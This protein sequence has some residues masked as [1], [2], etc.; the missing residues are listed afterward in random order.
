MDWKDLSG[1]DEKYAK[2]RIREHKTFGGK[3][4]E[5]LY[6]AKDEN[7]NPVMARE[8]ADDGHG[9]WFGIDINGD[10]RMFSLQKPASEGG[11]IEYATES[12]DHAL[13][14]MENT[15][16]RKQEIC[17][18]LLGILNSNESDSMQERISALEE[19]WN[20]LKDWNTPKEENFAKRYAQLMDEFAHHQNVIKQNVLDKQAIVEKAKE[21]AESTSWKTAQQ[22]FENLL[23][24]LKNIGSAGS[25]DDEI[26]QQF[27]EARSAFN[28]KRS[29]YFSQL[30]EIRAASKV[31]KEELIGQAK[32]VLENKN[33]KAATDK[34]NAL[35]E[36]WKKAGSSGRDFDDIL[37]EQF[38][39]IRKEF[40]D[41]RKAFYNEM[42]EAQKKSSEIKNSL[43]EEVR[44]IVENADF[45][46]DIT[47]RMKE[48][49]K[50]W[51]AAGFS[52]KEIN[53]A[54][55]ETFKEVKNQFWDA[56]HANSQDR[57]RE[58][59][60]RKEDTLKKIRTE[61]DDLQV[62]EY[63]TEDYDRIHS[64]QKRIEEKKVTAE[65]IE[66]D[67]KELNE[68]LDKQ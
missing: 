38:N 18:E 6:G 62:K 46:K 68:K 19:E 26:Y 50:E 20:G 49:D 54:L 24:E 5:V 25:L 66:N 67:I 22:G 43:I 41:K 27:K 53:D 29:E 15:I 37:W 10:H 39:G 47:E 63:E 44:K 60:S 16:I 13:E 57:F 9:R 4:V 55:W 1:F 34:M 21:L 51:K 23:K 59:I 48:I 58:I 32:E 42:R 61:I 31:K 30:D 8:G 7:G 56:K 65:S 35:M 2:V 33:F 3:V 17:R 14:D 28:K 12:G 11:E 36:E 64:I 40:F 52:G 45:S